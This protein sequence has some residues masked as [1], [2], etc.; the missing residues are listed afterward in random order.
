MIDLWENLP[1]REHLPMLRVS[2]VMVEAYFSYNMVP[3][4]KPTT[5]S[6]VHLKKW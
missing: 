6:V 4:H 2:L 5:S 1:Q 3:E